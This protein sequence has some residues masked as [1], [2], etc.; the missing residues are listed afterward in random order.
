MKNAS[1]LV[2]SVQYFPLPPRA[3][4]ANMEFLKTKR[5]GTV[6]E[7][8]LPIGLTIDDLLQR[9]ARLYEN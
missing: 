5:V 9:E 6:F 7:G 3:Y 1:M 2:K 8:F 4:A